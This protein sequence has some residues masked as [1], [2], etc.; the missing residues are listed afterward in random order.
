M[1]ISRVQQHSQSILG[2][3]QV[4]APLRIIVR[5]LHEPIAPPYPPVTGCC[6]AARQ[7]SV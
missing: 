7:F 3:Q 5:K 4:S 2:A 1:I 6:D